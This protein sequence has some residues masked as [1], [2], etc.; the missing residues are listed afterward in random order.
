MHGF[1][2]VGRRFFTC[3]AGEK[4]SVGEATDLRCGRLLFLLAICGYLRRE[5]RHSNGLM[6]RSDSSWVGMRTE[7]IA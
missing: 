5:I 3:F 7:T 2:A 1:C 4:A 6:A